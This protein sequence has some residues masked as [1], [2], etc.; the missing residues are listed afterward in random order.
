M[1]K[2]TPESARL[3]AERDDIEHLEQLEREGRF[4]EDA[5]WNRPGALSSEAL[6]RERAAFK[7]R[8][9]EE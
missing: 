7:V 3:E 1:D 9:D 5:D 8:P 6:S 2:Y 4:V